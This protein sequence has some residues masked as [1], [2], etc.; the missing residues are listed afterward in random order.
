MLKKK[1]LNYIQNPKS[2]R[3]G[4]VA[5]HDRDLVGPQLTV[6]P[7]L[8]GRAPGDAADLL[9]GLGQGGR[10]IDADDVAAGPTLQGEAGDH[11]ARGSSR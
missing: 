2:L 3:P 4:R 10:C 5:V 7:D 6:E 8:V 1:E 9:R 11:A